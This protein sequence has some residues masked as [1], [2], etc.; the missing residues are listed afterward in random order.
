MDRFA[1]EEGGRLY[2]RYCQ[3]CHGESGQGD[4]RFYASSLQPAPADFTAPAFRSS[5]TDQRLREAIIG[6]SASVGKSDLCPPW[7]KT[8][9]ATEVDYLVAYIRK[10]QEAQKDARGDAL[11]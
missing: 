3:P 7:G 9:L 8:F 11:P 2:T 5:H 6:G 4:G 1:V 10:L